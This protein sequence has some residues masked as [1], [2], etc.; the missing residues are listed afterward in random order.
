M[1]ITCLFLLFI[2]IFTF[3]LNLINRI[4]FNWRN[5]TEVKD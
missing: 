5:R 2:V 4:V 3:G 1:V